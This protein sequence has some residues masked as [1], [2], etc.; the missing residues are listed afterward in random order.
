L[1]IPRERTKETNN[2]RKKY[3]KKERMEEK[4]CNKGERIKE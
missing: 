1:L 2:N 3:R 4:K